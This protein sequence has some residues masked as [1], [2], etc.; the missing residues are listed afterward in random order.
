MFKEW[1]IKSLDTIIDWTYSLRAKVAPIVEEVTETY[2]D[3]VESID[4]IADVV[5]GY[6]DED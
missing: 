1:I 6:K 2:E 5:E 3:V 4:A